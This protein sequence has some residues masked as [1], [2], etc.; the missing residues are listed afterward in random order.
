MDQTPG[1]TCE[2]FF[3]ERI[4]SV[5]ATAEDYREFFDLF[6]RTHSEGVFTLAYSLLRNYEDARDVCQDTFLRAIRYIQQNPGSVPLKTNFRGWLC[7]IARHL[8]IDR[9]RKIL[10]RPHET[11][12]ESIEQP[13]AAQSP[14]DRAILSEDL[15]ILQECLEKLTE[16]ARMTVYLREIKGLSE[17]V[18]AEKLNSNP[19]AVCVALHRAR[20]ALRECVELAHAG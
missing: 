10:V 2:E 5:E 4:A 12:L 19:N 16:R 9:F 7:V 1:V 13:P 15:K 14:Q 11:S 20:K 8:V 18:I 6:W 3:R 17:K